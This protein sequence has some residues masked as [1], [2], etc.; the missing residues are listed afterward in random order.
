MLRAKQMQECSPGRLYPSWTEQQGQALVV[1]RVDFYQD[2]WEPKVFH[3]KTSHKL[4][5]GKQ[6]ALVECRILCHNRI[7]RLPNSLQW[8]WCHTLLDRIVNSHVWSRRT[9]HTPW[10]Q[11][12][13]RWRLPVFFRLISVVPTNWPCC[14]RLDVPLRNENKFKCTEPPGAN[15][16]S[17]TQVILLIADGTHCQR[18]SAQHCYKMACKKNC[19]STCFLI[20]AYSIGW[21]GSSS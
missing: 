11:G 13:V 10:R 7:G 5:C 14:C 19:K 15:I 20:L 16:F 9:M 6:V 3:K 12:P 2:K 4:D 8:N 17:Q 21:I 18:F 1:R